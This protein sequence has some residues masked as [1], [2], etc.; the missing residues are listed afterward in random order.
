MQISKFKSI[1]NKFKAEIFSRFNVPNDFSQPFF[2]VASEGDAEC[3][4][5]LIELCERRAHAQDS[6]VSFEESGYLSKPIDTTEVDVQVAANM[7]RPVSILPSRF[8]LD[9]LRTSLSCVVDGGLVDAS[10]SFGLVDE[11]RNG[12]PGT[13]LRKAGGSP[14]QHAIKVGSFD[15]DDKDEYFSVASSDSRS[16]KRLSTREARSMK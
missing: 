16:N 12:K 15:G 3:V 9:A 1:T 2:R 7:F 13:F 4:R 6:R 14:V 8:A 10:F 11:S 5:D